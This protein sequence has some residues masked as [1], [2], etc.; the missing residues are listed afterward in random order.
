MKK[1]YAI[2]FLFGLFACGKNNSSEES[3]QD[4]I[5]SETMRMPSYYIATKAELWGCNETTFRQ[6]VYVEEEK[7][8]YTCAATKEWKEVILKGDSGDKG[9]AG[10]NGSV[11]SK[12]DKGDAGVAG[13]KGDKGD[14][15]DAAPNQIVAIYQCNIPEGPGYQYS[16]VTVFKDNQIWNQTNFGSYGMCSSVSIGQSSCRINVSTNQQGQPEYI[17]STFNV[18]AKT[19]T[20]K[21]QGVNGYFASY[22]FPCIEMAL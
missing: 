21:N 1:F 10:I 20:W 17:E 6:L 2:I 8:F 9:D 22:D 12:G 7:V 4:V 13:G 11:G 3:L 19:M 15:G 5:T 16:T 18:S 14:K